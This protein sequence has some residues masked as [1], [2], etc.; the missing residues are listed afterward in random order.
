[1]PEELIHASIRFG[2]GRFNTE[3]EVDYA[4]D[5]VAQQVARLRELSPHYRAARAGQ[6]RNRTELGPQV[7]FS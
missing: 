1:V 7:R 4:L 2:L 5:R 6:E 3:E